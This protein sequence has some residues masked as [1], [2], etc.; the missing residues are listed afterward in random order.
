M[1]KILSRINKKKQNNE[2]S[3]K[4]KGLS[5]AMRDDLSYLLL[6]LPGLV[7]LIIFHYIPMGGVIIAFKNYVPRKGIFGSAWVGLKNFKYFFSSQDAWRTI[8]NTLLYS[9]DFLAVELIVG[10]GIS[11]LLYHMRSR[12]PLKI[13]HT[14]ILIPRFISI[15]IVAFI[16]YAILS[17]TYGVLNQVIV[18]LGGKKVQWYSEPSYW[19]LILTIVHIWQIA[20]S[21]SLYYYSSLMGMDQTLFEAA[22]IDGAGTWKKVWHI[23]IPHLIPIMTTMT[24]LGLGHV[25]T[26]SLGLHY[27]VPMKS[28][29]LYPTVDIINTYTYRALLG[30]NLEKSA[31]VGLFQNVVGLILV[32]T[33]NKI[34]QKI[35]PENSMF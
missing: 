23:A 8:R 18:A 21:G 33:V 30:G 14:V 19:P 5:R 34:V 32:V 27:Q 11:L 13:Y 3:K 28:G 31:A 4:R 15:T 20:G 16:A 2:I 6:C 29:T 1:S 12:I 22:S 10:V 9:L 26:G 24:I 25:F 17:P 35:S 7:F